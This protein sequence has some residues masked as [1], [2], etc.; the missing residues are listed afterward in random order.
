MTRGADPC[1][2]E[3]ADFAAFGSQDFGERRVGGS[4]RSIGREGGLYGNAIGEAHGRALAMVATR[5]DTSGLHAELI[6][7]FGD[8]RLAF[9]EPGTEAA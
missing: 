9:T 6:A 7:D 4:E 2:R 5:A 1:C 8:Q 3:A